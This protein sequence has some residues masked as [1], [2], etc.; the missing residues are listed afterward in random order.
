MI[1]INNFIEDI[2]YIINIINSTFD[3]DIAIFNNKCKLITSTKAY[4]QN[5]GN[6]VHAPSLIEVM[7]AG[8]VLVNN[9]GKMASCIG[10]RFKDNCPSTIELLNCINISNSTI[11][12][13]A[14]TS[15]TKEGHDKIVQ[16]IDKYTSLIDNFSKLISSTIYYKD[17]SYELYSCKCTISSALEL[18]DEGFIIAN[19]DGDIQF[20]NNYALELF[21]S[22]NLHTK[23]LYQL[24]DKNIL[25]TIFS[26]RAISNMPIK[27]NNA[28]LKI[29]SNPV[30]ENNKNIGIAIKIS[31]KTITT[32]QKNKSINNEDKP[33]SINSIKGNSKCM[34]HIKNKILKIQNSPSTVLITGE[35]GTGKGLLAKAI[36]YESI[37]SSKPFIIV[38]CTS[39]PENLFESE[40]F[41]Y[42]AGAFT[43]A[44]KEGKPGKFELAN[45]GT[46]FLEE[47][48]EMPLKL[49]SKLL[50]VL[51]DA[52]FER[53]GG[54]TPITVDVRIIA[55]TNKDILKLIEEKKF[56]S[57]LY[58]RL[59]VIPIELPSLKERKDDIIGIANEFLKKYN[60]K[61]YKQINNF[62][63]EVIEL[64]KLYDWPG[65]IRQLE[66]IIEYAVNMTEGKIITINDLPK[67]L[68]NYVKHEN[69]KVNMVKQNE[70]NLII[71][72][73]DKYGWDV[74][75]KTLAANE[76]GIGLR[77]LYRKLN[78]N[79]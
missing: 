62:D 50:S 60:N 26:G 54:I 48:G 27:I 14:F 37:R 38:N 68:L 41:G 20:I 15:F 73:I 65:N 53:V 40:L 24:F 56:R 19:S 5:K 18:V 79:Q 77:T 28:K 10:C 55:A 47:S 70:Y 3:I 61:L 9:P 21:S 39:I 44:K 33:Y 34:Q 23:S 22:C 1:I 49:Q 30:I 11:G 59:N 6:A 25:P 17:K 13:I 2:N 31:N 78:E 7:E 4:L 57:D 71:E 8:S 63:E 36:H 76:L 66:N 35:T 29:S 43:G 52:T 46:L 12:V 72:T 32:S 67:D 75:G 69:N 64:L 58:Y 45:E 51:Q 16:N 42:E 74:K